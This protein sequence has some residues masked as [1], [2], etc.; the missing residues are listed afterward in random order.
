[1][2]GHASVH[3]FSQ[4]PIGSTD[5][6]DKTRNKP[7]NTYGVQALNKLMLPLLWAIS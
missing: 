7:T 4:P 3:D 6:L 5:N 1:M 2:L